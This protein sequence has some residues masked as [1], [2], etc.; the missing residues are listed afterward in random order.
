M[1]ESV[2]QI[3]IDFEVYKA[4]VGQLESESDSYNDAL[5]RLL[6][7]PPRQRLAEQDAKDG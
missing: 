3:E 6:S 5:R 2:R 7:L 4:L 1:G